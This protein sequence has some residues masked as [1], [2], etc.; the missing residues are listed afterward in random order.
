MTT[1]RASL[2]DF[3]PVPWRDSDALSARIDHEAHLT[4]TWLV[5][6][7]PTALEW[8]MKHAKQHAVVWAQRIQQCEDYT[9]AMDAWRA[10]VSA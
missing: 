1:S 5:D 6:D 9:R 10:E 4:A 7:N 2:D 8:A 3:T